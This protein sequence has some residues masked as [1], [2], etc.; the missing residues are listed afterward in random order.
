MLRTGR[1]FRADT[2]RGAVTGQTELSHTAGNQQARVRRT[3]WCVTGNAAV[4]FHR[5]VFVNKRSLFVGVTL[6]AR[7]VSAGRESGLFELET[8]VRIVAIA[9]LH[10]S[11]QHFVMERQVELVLGLGVTAQAKLRFAGPE[12]LQI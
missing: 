10:R 9:A 4:G 8:A 2:V 11:F 6:D 5:R 3:V 12:Q 7:R 1:L